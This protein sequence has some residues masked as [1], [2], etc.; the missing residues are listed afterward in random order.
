MLLLLVLLI[1]PAQETTPNC[2][3]W[4][5]CRTEA[6]IANDRGDYERFHDL[7][8]RAVQTGPARD[9]E[10]MF[11]LARAQAI[12][13]RAH[14]ALVMIRRIAE[15]GVPV[16]AGGQEFAR[17]RT[18]P[19]WPAV[20]ALLVTLPRTSAP[21]PERTPAPAP[22]PGRIDVRPPS[23]RARGRTRTTPDTSPPVDPNGST[24]TVETA[25]TPSPRPPL[26]SSTAIERVARSEAARFSAPSFSAGGLAYDKVSRRFVVGDA[27]DRK[28]MV[29]NIGGSTAIDMVRA[30]S[31]GFEDVA[32]LA[33]DEQ[34][35]DLWVAGAGGVLHRLQLVSGRPLRAY[36]A[37]PTAGAVRVV[38]L[39][40]APSGAVIAL[41]ADGSRLLALGRTGTELQV[42]MALGVDGV[43]SLVMR[44]EGTALVAHAGGVL[45]ADL[46]RQTTRLVSAPDTV[47]LRGIDRLRAHRGTLIGLQSGS[48]ASRQVV[49]FTLKDDRR[50]TS[51]AVID[52]QGPH[53]DARTL[54]TIAGDELYYI[55]V[56][57]TDDTASSYVIRR[58]D[59]R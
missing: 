10:L 15:L 51:V 33:I 3:E 26:A 44:D 24:S 53:A 25:A 31:A 47:S 4:R 9:A 38:D 34:R 49:R 17:T 37:I 55:A 20:A 29:V 11:L 42:V 5:E 35:G 27:L 56:D 36:R 48:P 8:W 12:S 1:T 18:L 6:L 41:D 40:V 21:A 16:D 19:E 7:A 39:A 50:I 45:R 22:A 43:T 13:G 2:G 54:V 30:D 52:P 28:L 59:L 58:L 14:D 57:D 32:A 46:R 23:P